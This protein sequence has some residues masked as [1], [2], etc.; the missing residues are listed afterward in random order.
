ML[1]K[2]SYPFLVRYVSKFDIPKILGIR[3]ESGLETEFPLLTKALKEIEYIVVCAEYQEMTIGYLIYE[4]RKNY[5]RIHDI[6]VNPYY[7]RFGAGKSLIK[8]VKKCSAFRVNKR[9]AFYVPQEHLDIHL[10]LRAQSFV[11]TGINKNNK[12]RFIYEERE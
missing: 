6:C 7:R 11:C 5:I 10:F 8:Y 1:T 3:Y 4:K 9:I 2:K 12:Y